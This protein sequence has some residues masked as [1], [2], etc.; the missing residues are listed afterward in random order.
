MMIEWLKKIYLKLTCLEQDQIQDGSADFLHINKSKKPKIFFKSISV[1]DKTPSNALV[2]DKDFIKVVHK[3]IPYWALF[4]C[5]CGCNCI[6]SLS[7]Q[8]MHNPRWMASKSQSGRPTLYPSVWQNKDCC[9]HF[10]I[11][12]G[13]IYWCSNTGIEPWKAEPMHY[14]KPVNI[15]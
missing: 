13:R 14:T 11:E 15:K 4:R 7:L 6:I 3:G 1:V 12:D 9:S 2:G 5:P 8:K 10:W